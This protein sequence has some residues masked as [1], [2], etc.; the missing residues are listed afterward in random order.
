MRVLWTKSGNYWFQF[1]L[2][3][4]ILNLY[5]FRFGTAPSTY[6]H[7]QIL[8]KKY[9]RSIYHIILSKVKICELNKRFYYIC[10]VYLRFCF[11][12]QLL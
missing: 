5:D 8:R 12:R 3:N 2:V 9:K 11:G 4:H 1:P 7:L 10:Y 6:A